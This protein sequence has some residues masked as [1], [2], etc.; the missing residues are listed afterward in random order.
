MK[1]IKCLLLAFCAGRGKSEHQRA[2]YFLTGSS[3]DG[4]LAPQKQTAARF[5]GVRVEWWCKRPPGLDVNRD[6]RNALS[7]AMPNREAWVCP[8]R[9]ASG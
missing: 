1:R 6:A 7:G 9:Y 8:T 3:G 5:L 2:G 4:E